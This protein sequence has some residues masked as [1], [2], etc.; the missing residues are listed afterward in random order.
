MEAPA[1]H[2]LQ[3]DGELNL[4]NLFSAGTEWPSHD[5]GNTN[6]NN[7][8]WMATQG[9]REVLWAAGRVR[10][11]ALHTYIPVYQA[12]DSSTTH[13]SWPFQTS[14][15]VPRHAAQRT[16]VR[17]PVCHIPT[18]GFWQEETIDCPISIATYKG[19][20]YRCLVPR[21]VW[22]SAQSLNQ[23]TNIL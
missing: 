22:N 5:I 8:C 6:T 21:I 3:R 17:L 14:G 7:V 15:T 9:A 2:V 18:A 10:R 4:R 12:M 11:A 19:G 23:Q 13:H 16:W 1:G 20:K